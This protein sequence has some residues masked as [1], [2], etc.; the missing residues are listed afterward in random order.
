MFST[1]F[2]GTIPTPNSHL[3]KY[4][5]HGISLYK[6][7]LLQYQSAIEKFANILSDA[8]RE[9]ANR[10]HFLKDKNRFII[11]RSLLKV[12]LAEYISLPVDS[13]ILDI[14][15]NKKPY[16]SS[17]PTVFF[18]V[19]H[20]G[21]YALIGI[22]NHPIGIDIEFVNESFNYKEILPNIFNSV[23]IDDIN[24]SKKKH[25]TFFQYWTRKEAIVKAIGK[26][27]DDDI[28][29]IPVNDGTHVIDSRI[30]REF[31]NL[32]VLSFDMNAD[33]IGA[34]ATTQ[35]LK[36]LKQLEFSRIPTAKYLKS[37]I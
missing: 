31:K 13:M 25:T 19:S 2:S 7:E 32:S 14:D 15:P 9:R 4:D 26:G 17:H 21:D 12:L 37:L 36:D 16:L 28:T 10:Y 27:I 35:D 18:N 1:I 24:Q 22:S 8:E 30:F 5:N 29:R 3:N 23:E 34:V 20:S 11:C 33:Y 6:I